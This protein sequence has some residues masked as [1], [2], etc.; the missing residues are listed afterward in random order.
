[1]RV[2]LHARLEVARTDLARR[3]HQRRDRPGDDRGQAEREQR[4]Q[5][6]QRHSHR[7]DPSSQ[8]MQRRHGL[9]AIDLGEQGPA[10]RV[11]IDGP[12]GGEHVLAAVVL[13]LDE[14]AAAVEGGAR[15]VVGDRHRQDR[16]AEPAHLVDRAGGQPGVAEGLE[17]LRLVLDEEPGIDTHGHV[18]TDEIGLPGLAEPLGLPG[19]VVGERLRDRLDREAQDHDR[20]QIRPHE[21]R[22]GDEGLGLAER[23]PERLEVGELVVVLVLRSPQRPREHGHAA[24]RVR[25]RVQRRAEDRRLVVTEDHLERRR[26]DEHDVLEAQPIQR[27]ARAR[28]APWRALPRRRSCRWTTRAGAAARTGWPPFTM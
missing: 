16:G 27:R 18:R 21:H 9:A 17:E 13:G 19:A 3:P 10:Q 11:E 28:V 8:R 24:A 4:R 25:S 5:Q 15:A 20:H 26:I 1:M 2:D 12:V 6:R 14:A 22:A 7:Q 23:R